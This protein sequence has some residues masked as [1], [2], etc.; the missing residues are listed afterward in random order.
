MRLQYILF[1][2]GLF[3]VASCYDDLGNYD[4]H[5][6][7][8]IKVVGGIAEE[9]SAYTM[10]DTLKIQPELSFS[11]D[12]ATTGRFEYAWSITP[13]T[14]GVG[15]TTKIS[16]QRDLVYPVNLPRATYILT[17]GVKDKETKVEWST[18]TYLNVTTLFTNG[19]LMLGEKDGHAALDMVSIST[20]GD[21]MVITDVLKNSGLPPLKGPR[22]MISINYR[23]NPSWPWMNGCFLMTDDGTFEMDRV[24]MTSDVSTNMRGSVY[25]PEISS[26]FA[27]SDMLQSSY[28]RYLIGDNKLY[29]NN[30]L[31]SSGTFGNPANKYDK[32]STTYF[33]VFPEIIWGGSSWG[34][35][36]SG[37][38]MIY[39]MDGK[40]FAKFKNTSVNCDTL[41][42]N[43]GDPYTWKTGN[44]MIALFNSKFLSS[45]SQ[46]S[47]AVMKSPDNRYYLYSF[48]PALSAGP[49]KGNKYDI[50]S[51]PDIAQATKFA[52]SD[53]Y[54][55]MLYVVGA[56]L[57]ACEFLSS[58]ITHKELD[59][60]GTDPITM[61]YFDTYKEYGKDVFYVATYND[62][63]KGTVQ[64]YRLKDDPN[65]I[66][67][68]AVKDSRWKNLCKVTSMCWKWY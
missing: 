68:E 58:G 28:C 32:Y 36:L 25:D 10:V 64:K 29:I 48:Q 24:S 42:D 46:T 8:E 59:G 18:K 50:T 60:F 56:K 4:Y 14:L 39:D 52:F 13:A 30:S 53:R 31:S 15:K 67:I 17:F 20:L 65:D 11:Q 63:T 16:D 54:P 57:Y 2:L 47:Y 23:E 61:L 41:P 33:K 51:L 66:Q 43:A 38:Q 12:S 37:S 55:Y 44:D 62:Q 19:W 7:N 5:E 35:Y 21:T 22:K 45:G 26:D 34:A 3:V 49:K 6:I 9:Y 40:R 27:G 1:C